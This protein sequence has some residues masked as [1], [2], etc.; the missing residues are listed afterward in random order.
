MACVLP[1]DHAQGVFEESTHRTSRNDHDPIAP[2]AENGGPY[3]IGG[4]L[5]PNRFRE[6]RQK[7]GGHDEL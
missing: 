1:P 7:S 4:Q 6:I 5:N 2:A 3:A